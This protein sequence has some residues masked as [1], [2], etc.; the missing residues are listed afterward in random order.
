MKIM[1]EDIK[2]NGNHVTA[3]MS[4]NDLL[5]LGAY[6]AVQYCGGPEMEFKSG[7]P[8]IDLEEAAPSENALII[9]PNELVANSVHAP[10][11]QSLNL[12]PHHYV[13][14]MGSYTIGFANDN[15]KSKEN[16][17]TMNP[18]VFDNTYFKEVLLAERSKYLKTQ[19][20]LALLEDAE[21]LEW[22]QKFAEDEQLFF[23]LY[24]EAHIHLSELGQEGYVRSEIN[25]NDIVRGG[26]M[27]NGGENWFFARYA[28]ELFGLKQDD[29][30]K[31]DDHSIVADSSTSDEEEI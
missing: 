27:E 6:T 23:K 3:D 22:V 16:R 18:Y 11:F 12:A 29:I 1:H 26:Y 8:D 10:R 13:A 25:E 21:T 7:R 28:S 19:A 17:W 5:Q 31:R 2:E 20:D 4:Y 24:A 9:K 14:M 30:K 15:D